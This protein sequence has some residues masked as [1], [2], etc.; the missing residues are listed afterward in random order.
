MSQATRI[1]KFVS[2]VIAIAFFAGISLALLTA[3]STETSP[4]LKPRP[5]IAGQCPEHRET[6]RAPDSYYFRTNPLP[7]TPEQVE[8]GRLLYESGA[9]PVACAS[10]HGINGDGRG[11]AGKNLI[12]P[13]RNFACA[14]TMSHITDGQLF[15]VIESGS[16]EFHLPSR[17]GAQEIDRPA[18]RSRFT[19]MRAHRAY[20]SDTDIWEL[21][22][23]IRTL[24]QDH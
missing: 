24:Q 1:R 16:G 12:P 18:R 10:C 15:W 22:L 5:E 13:P 21:V 6:E 8:R 14:E 7:N 2:G 23:Y 3:C 11:P 9:K 19:A 20:L 4:Q 17:Q